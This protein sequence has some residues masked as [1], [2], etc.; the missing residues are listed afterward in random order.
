MHKVLLST[1]VTWTQN[2]CV[3]K[4]KNVCISFCTLLG[5][6]THV[7]DQMNRMHPG[8][9]AA[10]KPALFNEFRQLCMAAALAVAKDRWFARKLSTETDLKLY[11]V[12]AWHVTACL[13]QFCFSFCLNFDSILQRES[14]KSKVF[15]LS[16]RYCYKAGVGNLSAIMGRMNSALSLAGYRIN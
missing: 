2:D 16:N 13:T 8:S 3:H 5:L 10:Y 11:F 4:R 7:W 12:T 15:N 14:E 1:A 6:S 9:V